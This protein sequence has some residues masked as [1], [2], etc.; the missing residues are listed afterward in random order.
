VLDLYSNHPILLKKIKN[1]RLQHYGGKSIGDPSSSP[2]N[3][4]QDYWI[5]IRNH[6]QFSSIVKKS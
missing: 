4:K 2:K 5:S 3:L 1:L 6:N